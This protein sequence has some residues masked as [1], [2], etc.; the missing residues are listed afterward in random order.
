MGD[1]DSQKLL[2][3]RGI[4]LLSGAQTSGSQQNQH[5]HCTE[6]RGR[7]SV[8]GWLSYTRPGSFLESTSGP[9]LTSAEAR[10]SSC[11]LAVLYAGLGESDRAMEWLEKA[12]EEREHSLV[13]IKSDPAYNSLRKDPRFG[14]LLRRMKLD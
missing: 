10:V 11:S 8:G 9:I 6:K 1:D 3:W 14:M 7:L 5:Q 2:P 12:Y 4:S 13:A